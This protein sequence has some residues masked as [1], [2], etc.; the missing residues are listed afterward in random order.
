M[1]PIGSIAS[2]DIPSGE[3]ESILVFPIRQDAHENKWRDDCRIES[4]TTIHSLAERCEAEKKKGDLVHIHR[5]QFPSERIPSTITCSA[6]VGDVE[7]CEDK[8]VVHFIVEKVLG[9]SGVGIPATDEQR[10]AARR[11][12]F[13][14]AP[15]P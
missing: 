11:Q 1:F 9:D 4:I 10:M 8:A 5:G 14:R 6:Q 13:Y 15:A 7:Y 12:K 2:G 3:L